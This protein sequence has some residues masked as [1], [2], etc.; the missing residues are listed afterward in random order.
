VMPAVLSH[1]GVE[2]PSYAQAL[3]RVA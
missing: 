1:F 2:P 3:Q